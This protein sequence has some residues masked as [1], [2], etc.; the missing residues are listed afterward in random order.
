MRDSERIEDLRRVMSGDADALQRLVIH[1][2]AALRRAVA[3]ALPDDLRGRLDPDDI[4]QQAYIAAFRSVVASGSCTGRPDPSCGPATSELCTASPQPNRD[5]EGAVS[6]DTPAG[7]YTWLKAIALARLKDAERRLRRRKRDVAREIGGVRDRRDGAESYPDLLNRLS[8]GGSTPSRHVA[9]HEA[10]A[11][12]LTSLARLNDDQ[13]EVVRLRFLEARPV[14]EV[15]ERLGK[16]EG[17]VHMLC[18]RGLKALR[19]HLGSITN[20]LTHL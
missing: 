6:F 17:A 18:H 16:T 14:A 19:G 7:F 1:Y 12:V 2:H 11:A 13:R 5:R 20:Y 4:L 3:S 9:K 10:V 15:A 8:G